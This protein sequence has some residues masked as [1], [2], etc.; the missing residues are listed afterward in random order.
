MI[1]KETVKDSVSN[2][3]SAKGLLSSKGKT[4][5]RDKLQAKKSRPNS[6][7]SGSIIELFLTYS[8]NIGQMLRACKISPS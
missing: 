6:G 3:K 7:H 5:F 1:E 2:K 8:E 4:I